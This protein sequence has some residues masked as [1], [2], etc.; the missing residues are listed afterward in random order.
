MATPGKDDPVPAFCMLDLF[1]HDDNIG[2]VFMLNGAR[3]YITIMAEKLEGAGDVINEFKDFKD[4][5]DDSDNMFNFEE[6]VLGA[7]DEFTCKL[8]P[9]V[10][11]RKPITLLDYFSP[12]TYAFELINDRGRLR[13]IQ[14]SYTPEIHGDTSPRIQIV[15]VVPNHDSMQTP[16]SLIRDALFRPSA[17]GSES[18]ILRSSLPSVLHIPASQLQRVDD[19]LGDEELSDIPTKVRRVGIENAFF[20]KGGFRD[21]GFRR[22]LE[23]LS[24]INLSDDFEPPYR[25]S[26]I[27]AL[28]FWDNDD[29][30]LMGFLLEY[31]EGETLMSR[32]DDASKIQKT[33]WIRQVKA[34][35]R[36][37]HRAGIIWG[38]VK[39][40]NVMINTEGDAIVV[41]F[42]GG[43]CPGYIKPELQQTM[44][45]DM[46]G[47]DHMAEEMGV[48]GD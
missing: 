29:S 47:L 41:D 25:T 40:D 19:A 20:F 26:R 15:D 18:L 16:Q 12:P 5:L 17:L 39:P 35:V 22:E 8:A 44:Q 11:V 13:A 27:T 45:G 14:Q 2:Y 42:G 28:V 9:A 1:D 43:Y 6:W 33:K 3:F 48:R 4:D 24:R 32:R 10:A 23:I 34:T 46:I 38:D 7:L 37:L 30:C 36:R 21:Q 31:I